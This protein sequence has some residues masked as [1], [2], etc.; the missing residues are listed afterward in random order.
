MAKNT[1][2]FALRAAFRTSSIW[3]TQLLASAT[4][5]M[6]GQSLPPSEMKS[7][8]GSTTSSA[9]MLLSYVGVFMVF[10]PALAELLCCADGRFLVVFAV[11][12]QRSTVRFSSS[13]SHTRSGAR[14]RE[15]RAHRHRPIKA[16]I[17]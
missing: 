10:P 1:R 2:S 4:A 6:L 16:R 11:D 7:L 3:G 15:S 14:A 5:L 8:Y 13:I 17:S 9:V 12:R